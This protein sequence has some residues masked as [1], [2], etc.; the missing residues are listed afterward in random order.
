[1]RRSKPKRVSSLLRHP[2]L[3]VRLAYRSN[4]EV[5]RP[6]GQMS[7]RL[8]TARLK[9]QASSAQAVTP[10]LL[11]PLPLENGC[12][13]NDF[14]ATRNLSNLPLTGSDCLCIERIDAPLD[15]AV[16][17]FDRHDEE[18]A[19][20]ETRN[21]AERR[22]KSVRAVAKLMPSPHSEQRTPTTIFTSPGG[23]SVSRQR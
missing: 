4:D 2:R 1:M 15:H 22:E 17:G 19:L 12:S 7:C 20:T 5:F 9:A 10:T 8:E 3:D 14:S 21:V 16:S 13:T 11:S 6:S 23:Q 18:R